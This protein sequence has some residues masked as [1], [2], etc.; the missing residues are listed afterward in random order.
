MN[1]K[2]TKAQRKYGEENII[3]PEFPCFPLCLCAFVVR[4]DFVP[5]QGNLPL[6][7][8]S[9]W[10]HTCCAGPAVRPVSLDVGR[11]SD[12]LVLSGVNGDERDRGITY[13]WTMTG[14]TLT[15]PG[16]E[17]VTAAHV[18]V[19][20]RNGRVGPN[21]QPDRTEIAYTANTSRSDAVAL[22]AGPM[23]A[24]A[25]A[26]LMRRP[27]DAAAFTITLRAPRY[28]PDGDART[29]GVQVDRITLVPVRS[30]WARGGGLRVAMG[31]AA[32]AVCSCGG[33]GGAGT[34]VRGMGWG[35]GSRGVGRAR[36]GAGCAVRVA[37]PAR[38]CECGVGGV[39]HRLPPLA[40]PRHA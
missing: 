36:G 33:R 9:R 40:R 17:G 14:T 27:E 18:E 7:R 35:H 32:R 13:R 2:V 6:R 38:S 22:A 3:S 8:G 21:G 20:A 39:G 5:S 4:P 15:V 30:D 31:G 11:V 29:L 28:A 26:D 23:W 19:T 1:H 16:W 25:N 34:V 24:S 12:R 37:S 10:W